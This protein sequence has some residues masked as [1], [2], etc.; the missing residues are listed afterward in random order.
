[1]FQLECDIEADRLVGIRPTQGQPAALP[2]KVQSRRKVDGQRWQ[3]ERALLGGL[4][5]RADPPR[6]KM[7]TVAGELLLMPS[8]IG[9]RAGVK[10]VG[11]APDN[12]ARG[13]ARI[14]GVY[15]LVDAQTLVPLALLDGPAVTSLRT[16]AVSALAAR[17]LAPQ[18]ARTLAVFGTGPQARGHIDAL[19]ALLP[20]EEVVVVGRRPSAV[21]VL[22]AD[23]RRRGLQARAGA[24]DSA[25][26][27]D[28]TVCATT[29]S[30]PLFDGRRVPDGG[31]VIAVGSHSAEAREL[32][33][34]LMG[35][36][37]VVVEDAEVALHEAGDVV[38]AVA[39]GSL[40]PGSIAGLAG[41]VRA[42]VTVDPIRPKVFKSVGMSWQDLITATEIHR[43]AIGVVEALA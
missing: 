19:C 10:I 23:A 25:A 1:M 9:D 15:V 41:I 36:S 14:Q 43:R 33:S 39:D 35:R 31:L 28:V 3:L 38:H 2:V 26:E 30:T 21:A 40:L 20:I 5:P 27:A 6:T 18:R 34:G 7:V 12:P 16:P 29:S 17:Y 4:D 13:V 42:A 8:E 22:L 37:Q 24:P 11:L 32:D